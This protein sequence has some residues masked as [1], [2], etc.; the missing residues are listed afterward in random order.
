MFQ[1]AKGSH[2]I[3]KGLIEVAKT[4]GWV[5]PIHQPDNVMLSVFKGESRINIYYT[6]MTVATCINH[7]IKGKTQLFR[8]NVTP[9]QLVKILNDPRVHTNKGYYE[10][11]TKSKKR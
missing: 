7:P 4:Y 8:R 2:P 1:E 3:V 6:T 5:R 10:K 11:K 9:G